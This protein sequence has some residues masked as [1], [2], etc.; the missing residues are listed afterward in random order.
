MAQV[1]KINMGGID[2]DIRD[3]VLEQEVANIK[4]IVNQGTINN[5]ADEE[6]LTSENNLLKLKDRSALNGM[7]YV[8][9]RKN[10]TFAEQVTKANTIYEIRYDFDLGGARLNLPK[11]STLYFMGGKLTNGTIVGN[12]STISASSAHIVD[13]C[14]LEG[15]WTN[16]AANLAWWGANTTEGFDNSAIINNAFRSTIPIVEVSG[17]YYISKPIELPYNKVIKGRAGRNNKMTGFYANDNFSPIVVNFPERNGKAAFSKSVSGMFYHRDTTKLEMHDIFIDAR[18]KASFA[19]E[20]IDFYGSVDIYNCYISSATKVGLLQYAC[21]NPIIEQLYIDNCHIG[22]YMSSHEFKDGNPLTDAFYTGTYMGQPNLGVFNNLSVL[23]CNYGLI[24]DGSFDVKLDCLE[25]AHNSIAG[26]ILRGVS[27]E[28][29]KYYSEGDSRCTFYRASNG[30]KNDAA[31]GYALQDLIENNLDGYKTKATCCKG[32]DVYIRTPLVLFNAQITIT[33]AEMSYNP[34]SYTKDNANSFEWMNNRE[35]QGVDGLILLKRSVL[36]ADIIRL[37]LAPGDTS[38]DSLYSVVISVD[39]YTSNAKIEHIFSKGV[40]NFITHI[41]QNYH[42]AQV[43]INSVRSMG[44]A[45]RKESDFNFNIEDARR[46]HYYQKKDE[47]MCEYYGM[48]NNIPLYYFDAA[49]MAKPIWWHSAE[50]LSAFFGETRVVK[51]KVLLKV[52]NECSIFPNISVVYYDSNY[53][54]LYNYSI[55]V[56]GAEKWGKGV[57]ELYTYVPIKTSFD[58]AMFSLNFST[59]ATSKD[60]AVSHIYI[61]ASDDDECIPHNFTSV[62]FPRGTTAQRPAISYEGQEYFDLNL[63]KV[64]YAN[65]SKDGWVD[66]TGTSV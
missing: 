56:N 21:E 4:P 34:R 24:I 7:G 16:L 11:N 61:Y 37:Y 30:E 54:A 20:H 18:Y 35:P 50:E 58:F 13:N 43:N 44:V 14:T 6:D 39:N 10:K 32:E 62:T 42:S 41:A 53:N 29:N 45:D 31:V 26:A 47:R 8:I 1:S 2:Y 63:H 48:V 52:I 36:V 17:A 38:Y 9:L 23:S 57:Y 66:A 55:N 51:V 19:I 33:S 46:D 22:L 3:K 15:T 60:Y 59:G 25:T 5:A 27:G 28:I 49:I 12:D 40:T 65:Y 64:I